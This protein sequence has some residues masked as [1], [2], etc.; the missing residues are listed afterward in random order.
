MKTLYTRKLARKRAL[1]SNPYEILRLRQKNRCCWGMILK[2]GKSV[3][4]FLKSSIRTKIN[5]F[6]EKTKVHHFWNAFW[7]WWNVMKRISVSISNT[8]SLVLE[9]ALKLGLPSS[10]SPRG[11]RFS[12]FYKPPSHRRYKIA[13]LY[14][15]TNKLLV[16]N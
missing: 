1:S 12:I 6:I 15:F 3:W 2:S 5:E 8:L 11:R 14:H 13:I 4:I 9:A 7:N 16:V 10:P